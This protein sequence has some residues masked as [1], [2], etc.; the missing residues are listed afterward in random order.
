[1]P[2]AISLQSAWELECGQ[3]DAEIISTFFVFL[4]VFF[5]GI[6]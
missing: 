1:M 2:F 6:V 5:A 4:T 3:N